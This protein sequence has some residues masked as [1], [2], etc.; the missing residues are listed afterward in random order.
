SEDGVFLSRD[1]ADN[2]K[3]LPAPVNGAQVWSLALSGKHLVAGLCPAGIV[4]SS[5]GGE[6]WQ[7][8]ETY[9]ERDCPRIRHTRVTSLLFDPDNPD[10]LWAGVEIDGVHTSSDGGRSWKRIGEGLSSADIHGLASVPLP[11]GS[12]R[13][14]ATTNRDLNLSEDG[15]QSWQP[16]G[17]GKSLPWLYC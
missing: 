16:V 1:G 4:H 14:L 17:I 7:R 2:W 6:T 8:G 10:R 5:D 11:G 13:L 12:R 15:G 9:M 3:Q